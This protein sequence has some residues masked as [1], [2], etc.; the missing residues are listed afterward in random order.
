[1][2]LPTVAEVRAYM[3]DYP[4]KNF[5]YDDYVFEDADITRAITWASERVSAIPPFRES[6]TAAN[7]P[8]WIMLTGVLAQL[9]NMKYIH[10]SL[11]YAPGI[12]EN[13]LNIR[14]GELAPIF[15]N[16][17]T[18]FDGAFESMVN[19]YKVGEGLRGSYT[20]VKSP[21][22]RIS[23]KDTDRNPNP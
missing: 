19:K 9:F 3:S 4:I 10:Y 13:G 1:M 6:T 7:I 18:S 20:R 8:K 12:V 22:D 16:L 17:F 2:A 23:R 11:N 15:Q 5:K 14:E 21:Y